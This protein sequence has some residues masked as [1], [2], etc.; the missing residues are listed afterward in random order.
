MLTL[1]IPTLLAAHTRHATPSPRDHD[2]PELLKLTT[3]EIR[4]LMTAL[5]IKPAQRLLHYLNWSHWRQAH[6]ARARHLHYQR[7]STG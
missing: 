5:I 1:A 6:Q 2:S 7:R 4:H 3:N